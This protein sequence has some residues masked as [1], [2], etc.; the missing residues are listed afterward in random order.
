LN[1]PMNKTASKSCLFSW[2]LLMSLFVLP[3]PEQLYSQE[4]LSLGLLTELSGT[5][6]S[7]GGHHCKRGYELA[8]LA[9]APDDQVG[10]RRINLIFGDS[11]GDGKTAVNEFQK[12]LQVDKVIAVVSNRSQ[13][14]MALNPLSSRLKIP[15]IGVAGHSDFICQNS[16]GFRFWPS[17]ALEGATLADEVVKLGYRSAAI[18]SLEDEWMM[19]FRDNFK[20]AFVKAGGKAVYD[21]TVLE[22]QSDFDSIVTKIKSRQPDSVVV[23]L[24][25]TQAGP[26]I[27]KLRTQGLKAPLFGSYYARTRPVIESA[28][29]EAIEGLTLV[30]LDLD[31]PEFMSLFERS[32]KGA[33]PTPITYTCFAAL[34]FVLQGVRNNPAV[35]NTEGLE[36]ILKEIK[37]VKMP[38]GDLRMAGREAQYKLALK[39]IHNGIVTAQKQ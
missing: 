18:V 27:R 2:L 16:S 1:G 30:E 37:A 33:D 9:F 35:E 3:G 39:R 24:G 11:R 21:E 13:V 20:A 22:A 28:G 19:S 17:A 31:K 26:F 4:R 12:L 5:F 29:K 7:T 10:G 6:A 14:V 8:R 15:L 32:F 23:N 36:K 25:P 38:D 34:T